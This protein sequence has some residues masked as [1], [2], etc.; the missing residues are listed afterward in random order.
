MAARQ[1]ARRLP[2]CHH[3]DQLGAV[4]VPNGRNRTV[5]DLAAPVLSGGPAVL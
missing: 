5:I 4:Q 2:S 1:A 3:G